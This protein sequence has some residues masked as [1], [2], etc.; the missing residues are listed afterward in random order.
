MSAIWSHPIDLKIV[1]EF[2]KNTLV[3]HLNIQITEFGDKTL[4]GTMPVNETTFQPFR[5]LHGGASCV[6]AESLGSIAANLTLDNSVE[7]AVGQHIEA[8]HLRPVT[9]GTVTGVA[10]NVHKGKT[11]QLWK[12]EIFNEDKKLICDSK[13][14]MAIIK[15]PN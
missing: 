1:N 3:A 10:T 12:I 11:S 8:T 7:V 4:T 14:L 5:L 2:N 6:L 9:G 15:K 13:I